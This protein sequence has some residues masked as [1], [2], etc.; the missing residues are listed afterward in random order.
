MERNAPSIP[1]VKE[2]Y[3]RVKAGKIATTAGDIPPVK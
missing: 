2:E 3:D 1:W